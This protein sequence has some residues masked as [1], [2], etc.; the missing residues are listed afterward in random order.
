MVRKKFAQASEGGLTKDKIA[1]LKAEYDKVIE[2]A[3]RQL[4]EAEKITG[5]DI[6]GVT[7]TSRQATAKGHSIH[8]PG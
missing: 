1:S 5:L 6:S 8:E 4:E 7:G 3:A 2:N